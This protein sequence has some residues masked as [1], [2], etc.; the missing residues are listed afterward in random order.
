MR[1]KA[2]L[3]KQMKKM[4]RPRGTDADC[5][6]CKGKGLLPYTLSS[7]CGRFMNYAIFPCT[8][9]DEGKKRWK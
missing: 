3:R 4:R 5:P 2:E 8:C 7:A 6:H 9:T 1:T